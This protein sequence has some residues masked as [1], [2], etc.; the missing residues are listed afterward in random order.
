V[1]LD[2]DLLFDVR[3]LPNPFY[4]EDLKNLSGRD[5]K[6]RDYVMNSGQVAEFLEKLENLLTF[7]L[8]QYKKEGRVQVIISIG[9]TGG[10]H[11]SVVIAEVLRTFLAGEG[12]NTLVFHRDESKGL[13]AA[14]G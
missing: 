1:P 7:L 14:Q 13:K 8:A 3:F 5:E 6:V 12:Y 2:T 11:R 4:I 10:Q 9:C